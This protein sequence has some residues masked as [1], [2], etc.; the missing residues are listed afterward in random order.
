MFLI[1]QFEMIMSQVNSFPVTILSVPLQ[2]RSGH[3]RWTQFLCAPNHKVPWMLMYINDMGDGHRSM[4]MNDSL[5]VKEELPLLW[6]PAQFF[7]TKTCLAPKYWNHNL[8]VRMEAK[9]AIG[10]QLLS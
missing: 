3:S 10:F 7:F 8:L 9:E 5:I 1:I 2:P 6:D 4:T